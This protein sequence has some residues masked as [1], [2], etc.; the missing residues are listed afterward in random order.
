[1]NALKGIRL[2]YQP[3]I[4]FYTGRW[5]WMTLLELLYFVL[6]FFS[7]WYT[8]KRCSL[9][10]W[11]GRMTWI[12]L[13]ALL[14]GTSSFVIGRLNRT[15][16]TFHISVNAIDWWGTFGLGVICW[17]LRIRRGKNEEIVMRYIEWWK[18]ALIAFLDEVVGD[19]S[20][21]NPFPSL[22]VIIRH[23]SVVVVAAASSISQ[24]VPRSLEVIVYVAVPFFF[25]R[26]SFHL[27]VFIVDLFENFGQGVIV[28]ECGGPVVQ[29][30]F[31]SQNDYMTISL[32]FFCWLDAI[33]YKNLFPTINL[34]YCCILLIF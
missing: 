7:L 32:I 31:H 17:S 16:L 20:L 34:F 13:A 14:R 2:K 30:I 33:E 9:I 22:E 27:F 26:S 19:R 6:T 11:F 1:M 5:I 23:E 8:L 28:P 25:F 24:S 4:N 18:G 3:Q 15:K 12:F 10:F 21:W 29:W